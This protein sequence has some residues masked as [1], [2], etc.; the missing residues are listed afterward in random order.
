MSRP[1]RLGQHQASVLC[2]L[3]MPRNTLAKTLHI[4]RIT[5]AAESGEGPDSKA[6]ADEAANGD[7]IHQMSV[8]CTADA[9][10]VL[11]T[12]WASKSFAHRNHGAAGPG[13]KFFARFRLL[14]PIVVTETLHPALG[15]HPQGRSAAPFLADPHSL[16]CPVGAAHVLLRTADRD[17]GP[18]SHKCTGRGESPQ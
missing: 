1:R 10:P 12:S 11:P 9:L 15:H 7:T 18:P 3:V 8:P 16:E 4:P 13:A 6:M 5:K 17:V 14:L 2:F